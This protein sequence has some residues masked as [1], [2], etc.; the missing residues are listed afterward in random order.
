MGELFYGKNVAY[1]GL[2]RL[3]TEYLLQWHESRHLDRRMTRIR[4]R[5]QFLVT[6][7]EGFESLD[8][9]PK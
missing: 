8:Y 2:T 1:E 5:H 7:S 3:P 9:G 4:S 6:V